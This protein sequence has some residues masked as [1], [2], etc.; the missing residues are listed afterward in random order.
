M[1]TSLEATIVQ[2]LAER[3]QTKTT[4]ELLKKMGATDETVPPSERRR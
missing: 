4:V 1:D 2:I 3:G